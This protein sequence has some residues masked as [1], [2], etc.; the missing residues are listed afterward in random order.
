MTG[1]GL[2]D[3]VEVELATTLSLNLFDDINLHLAATW[4]LVGR[5]EQG[6]AARLVNLK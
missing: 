6:H 2:N 3:R 4:V 1:Q 5:R